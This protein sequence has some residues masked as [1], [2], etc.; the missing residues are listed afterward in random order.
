M[1]FVQNFS[2]SQTLG[3]P[4]VIDLEDTSTG[5]IDPLIVSR[6]VIITNAANQFITAAGVSD[7]ATSTAWALVDTQISIDC[8]PYDM[9]VY[10]RVNW[11][12]AG[13][14]ALYTK[15]TLY[16]FY[17]YTNDFLLQLTKNQT[18]DPQIL[19][20]TNYWSDKSTLHTL[21]KDAINAVQI[22]ADI[23][24]AQ[25]SLNAAQYLISNS[26]NFF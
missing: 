4:S 1:A 7:T 19:Q 10:I 24:S 25:N 13:G 3:N 5:T 15:I 21:L 20:D 2:A 6:E 22:G 23:Y 16:G 18:A 11:L 17:S 8:L 9:A 12:D 26:A 14:S